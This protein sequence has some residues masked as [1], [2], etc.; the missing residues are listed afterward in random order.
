MPSSTAIAKAV[1]LL[2]AAG[3]PRE[4]LSTL[5]QWRGQRRWSDTENRFWSK[6]D[7]TPTCWLWRGYLHKGY[8]HFSLNGRTTSAHRFAYQLLVGPIPEGLVIDHLCHVKHC[9]NAAH[10]EAVTQ[11]VN[12]QRGAHLGRPKQ[13]HCKRGHP[14]VQ[15][16]SRKGRIARV[17]LDCRRVFNAKSRHKRKAREPTAWTVD[18]LLNLFNNP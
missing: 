5:E 7:K 4:A 3:A 9:V 1:T 12:T 16:V 17:C 10:L 8:A 6:V 15:H 14:I 11:K 2:D 18:V 13:T